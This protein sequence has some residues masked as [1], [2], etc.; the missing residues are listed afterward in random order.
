LAYRPASQG[1]ASIRPSSRGRCRSRSSKCDA[2]ETRSDGDLI[3]GVVFDIPP[4]EK[5]G[6]DK[7]E[8]LGKGYNERTV[9]LITRSGDAMTAF[10]YCADKT[11]IAG[12]LFPYSWY[13]ELVLKGAT[14]HGLPPDYIARSIETVIAT[15]GPVA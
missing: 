14:E 12:G 7:A 2:F 3:W 13:K 10:T 5:K 8:G 6:L 9:D 11:A 1:G 4:S 15:E